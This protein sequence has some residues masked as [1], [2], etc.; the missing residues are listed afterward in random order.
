MEFKL[1]YQGKLKSNGDAR[2]KHR[3]RLIFHQQ[4]KNLWN[5]PPLAEE[6]EWIALPT[7]HSHQSPTIKKVN[8]HYFANLVCKSKGM[9]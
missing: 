4:L 9:F 7:Q 2:E 3:I 1:V 5:Y 6:K 8:D